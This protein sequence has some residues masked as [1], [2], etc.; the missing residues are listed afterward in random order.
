MGEDG[1]NR[2]LQTEEPETPPPPPDLDTPDEEEADKPFVVKITFKN[3]HDTNQFLESVQEEL[4]NK[5]H[6]VV[7]VTGGGL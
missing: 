1:L 2:L 5:Y 6:A 4:N 3:E 7:N